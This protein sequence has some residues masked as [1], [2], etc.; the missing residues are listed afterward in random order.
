MKWSYL[1]FLKKDLNYEC[2]E[3]EFRDLSLAHYEKD[4][5][6]LQKILSSL[7]NDPGKKP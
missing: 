4:R 7:T 1:I 6:F 2:F 5:E 3:L